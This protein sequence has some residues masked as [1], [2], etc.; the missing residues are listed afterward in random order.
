MKLVY[1]GPLK[2]CGFTGPA[3]GLHYVARPGVAFAV[4]ASD[5]PALLV[6]YPGLLTEI[7]PPAPA[8]KKVAAD[9]GTPEEGTAADGTL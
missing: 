4:E 2:E 5:G 8:K 3:S 7:I 1:R 6:R 9:E